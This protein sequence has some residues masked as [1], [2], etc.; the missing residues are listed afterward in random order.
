M[1]RTSS[2][3]AM[4]RVSEGATAIAVNLQ[5]IDPGALHAEQLTGLNNALNKVAAQIERFQNLVALTKKT[6][7]THTNNHA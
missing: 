5:R 3:L 2:I 7:S 1:N 4:L 6:P